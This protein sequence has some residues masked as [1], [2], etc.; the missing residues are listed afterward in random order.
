MLELGG[1]VADDAFDFRRRA[2]AAFAPEPL[3]ALFHDVEMLL[4]PGLVVSAVMWLDEREQRERR[5]R[6]GRKQRR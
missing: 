1:V 2:F 5:R 4:S 3:V 6:R